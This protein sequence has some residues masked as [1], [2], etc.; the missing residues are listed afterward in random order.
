VFYCHFPDKLLADGAYV[1]GVTGTTRAGL[2]K[3]LYRLP[4]DWLEE[5]TTSTRYSGSPCCTTLT[6]RI[7]DSDVILANSRFTSRVF[8]THFSSIRGTPRVVYPGIN[9]DAYKVTY[10][11]KSNDADVKQIISYVRFSV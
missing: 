9:I 3:R 7:G 10:D 2:L 11:P 5:A 1:E 8:K 6:R 4:M